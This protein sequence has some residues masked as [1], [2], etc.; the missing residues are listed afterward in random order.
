[1]VLK[2]VWSNSFKVCNPG[3]VPSTENQMICQLQS[4]TK[5][6]WNLGPNDLKCVRACHLVAGGMNNK[7]RYI[8]ES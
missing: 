3:F 4:P 5:M 1:M 6:D 7:A 2:G 8:V